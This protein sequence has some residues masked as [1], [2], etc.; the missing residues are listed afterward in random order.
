MN[1][2]SSLVEALV[3]SEME[4]QPQHE[5]VLLLGET[6]SYLIR[7]CGF[8]PLPL[9]IQGKIISKAVFDH[10]IPTSFLKRLQTTIIENEPKCVFTPADPRHQGS[11]VVLTLEQHRGAPIIIPIR[12]TQKIGRNQTHNLITSVYGKE[13]PDPEVKWKAD[14]LLIWEP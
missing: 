12:M 13:G 7:H 3:K 5:L 2:Y 6:P 14:G 9:S 1:N 11:V 10:G 4:G 8:P